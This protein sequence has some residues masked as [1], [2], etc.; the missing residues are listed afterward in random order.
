MEGPH[1]VTKAYQPTRYDTV[2]ALFV[3]KH[4]AP[5]AHLLPELKRLILTRWF[6]RYRFFCWQCH[7]SGV[8]QVPGN[9]ILCWLVH[10]NTNIPYT[11]LCSVRCATVYWANYRLPIWRLNNTDMGVVGFQI[12][13][14]RH[15]LLQ[16]QHVPYIGELPR[17]P[18]PPPLPRLLFT[19]KRI[20]YL[21]DAEGRAKLLAL[22][23]AWWQEQ[24]Q[25][26]ERHVY[27]RCNP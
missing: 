24:E 25:L 20:G 12:L 1:L 5:W 15:L 17:I 10:E 23:R 2:L 22:Q 18:D 4:S 19:H 9:G 11:R 21:D 8:V 26:L 3:F 7:T 14:Y 13:N 27:E 16:R 6:W